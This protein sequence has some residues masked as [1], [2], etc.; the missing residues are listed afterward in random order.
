MK[1]CKKGIDGSKGRWYYIEQTKYS[2]LFQERRTKPVK[3]VRA[4]VMVRISVLLRRGLSFVY[5]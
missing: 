5:A 1:K 4:I 3:S 2:I